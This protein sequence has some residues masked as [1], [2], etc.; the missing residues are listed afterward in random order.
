MIEPKKLRR[1]LADFAKLREGD[2]RIIYEMLH[3]E[4]IIIVHFIGYRSEIYKRK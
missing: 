1:N 3:A 4:E 2:Y